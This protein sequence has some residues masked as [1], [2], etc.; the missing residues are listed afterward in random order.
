MATK[1][2]ATPL[3]SFQHSTDAEPSPTSIASDHS[4]L[5]LDSELDAL[6]DHIQD[7]IEEQGEASVEAMDRLQLFCQAMDVKVDRIGRF[8]RV[9]E[10]RA[11]YCR[12]VGKVRCPREKGAEQD[13]A[14]PIHGALLPCQPRPPED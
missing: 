6:L 8:L 2:T 4:L 7:E 9:M 14:H 12:K 3:I 1:A 11:D 5:E 13:R 10:T